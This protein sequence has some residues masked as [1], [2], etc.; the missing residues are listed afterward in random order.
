M[1]PSRSCHGVNGTGQVFMFLLCDALCREIFLCRFQVTWMFQCRHDGYATRPQQFLYFFPLPQGHG[2]LRPT[3]GNER[4]IG[5]SIDTSPAPSPSPSP[6]TAAIAPTGWR[7]RASAVAV[8]AV[9]PCSRRR[10]CGKVAR[11]FSKACR[12]E[13]LRKRLFRTSFLMFAI[14]STNMSY[15]R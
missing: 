7:M 4:R 10:N 6:P 11:K 2:S 5:R 13:V 15:T 9:G 12:L 3:F 14:N 1:V 8:G